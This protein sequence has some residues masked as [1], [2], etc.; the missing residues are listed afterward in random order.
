[1]LSIRLAECFDSIQFNSICAAPNDNPSAH[2]ITI[3]F[4]GCIS[5]VCGFLSHLHLLL[6]ID[7]NKIDRLLCK[8]G[9]FTDAFIYSSITYL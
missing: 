1:M 8:S 7:K 9:T 4:V 6:S 2:S 3:I 5:S